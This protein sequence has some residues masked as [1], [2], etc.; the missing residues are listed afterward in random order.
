M[1]RRLVSSVPHPLRVLCLPA[2]VG[3]AVV[4]ALAEDGNL[5]ESITSRV[6][7]LFEANRDAVVK[8][9]SS[10]RH[11][12][13]EGTGFYT[14]PAGT[15]FTLIGVLGD[16]KDISVIQP[17]GRKLDARVLVTDPRTGIAILKVDANT[18][19]IPLADSNKVEIATPV[20]TIGYPMG[21]DASP[22]FGLV[23]GMDKEYLSRFFRVTHIRANV[24]VQRG[25]GGAPALDMEGRA[26]GVV[27]SG[28]DGNSACYLV[29]IN[30]AEKIHMDFARFGEL[31][32]GRIGATVEQSNRAE[33][34][35]VR[36]ADIDPNGPAAKAG[37]QEGDI[38]IQVGDVPI[39]APED[40]FD[41]SFYLT[42]GDP[43]T[44]KVRRNGNDMDIQ[45]RP[46]PHAEGAV[47]VGTPDDTS[48]VGNMPS[49]ELDQK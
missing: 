5:G 4:S 19:F 9:Q 42:A 13:I 12:R 21:K 41:A 16:G 27:F 8:I 2:V 3:A 20:M 10:D 46:E 14:D 17:G 35:G 30:A 11:G 43:A 36:L 40:I 38:L 1:R 32:P 39:R 18:P 47:P 28:V 6:R 26:I 29:P 23:A 44:V 22:S 37:L 49:F 34:P 24:P 48:V 33:A 31:R 15:I 25:L 45:I 7:E